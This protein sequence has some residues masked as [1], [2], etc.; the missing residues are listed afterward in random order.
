MW[1]TSYDV[2]LRFLIHSNTSNRVTSH[3]VSLRFRIMLLTFTV[4]TSTVEATKQHTKDFR[5]MHDLLL[6]LRG[7]AWRRKT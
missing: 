7:R 1:S 2:T 4:N 3:D 5:I 6:V